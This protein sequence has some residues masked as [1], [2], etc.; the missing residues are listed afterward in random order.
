MFAF[1]QMVPYSIHTLFKYYIETE[2][3]NAIAQSTGH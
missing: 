1:I 3:S 2:I